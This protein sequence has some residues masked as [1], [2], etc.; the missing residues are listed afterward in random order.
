VGEGGFDEAAVAAAR[1]P[2]DALAFEQHDAGVGVAAFGE[3]GR[4]EPGV[5]AADDGEV[6]LHG[7]GERRT[8]RSF[9]QVVE[10][11]RLQP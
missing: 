7:R 8:N 1:R 3:Q 10:P 4:P 9:G 2:A 11:E 5:A 6:G